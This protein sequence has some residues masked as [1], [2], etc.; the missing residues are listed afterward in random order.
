MNNNTLLNVFNARMFLL[1]CVVSDLMAST[2]HAYQSGL[3]TYALCAVCIQPA[4]I[5]CGDDIRGS[6]KQHY[7]GKRSWW[8]QKHWHL[9]GRL[10]LICVCFQNIDRG[11]NKKPIGRPAR[12]LDYGYFFRILLATMLNSVGVCHCHYVGHA[13]EVLYL[14]TFY[15]YRVNLNNDC[16]ENT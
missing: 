8:L 1:F 7:I 12:S 3:I 9:P 10:E 13:L 16:V 11:L 15:T 6:N 5:R 4:T 14:P 2:Q